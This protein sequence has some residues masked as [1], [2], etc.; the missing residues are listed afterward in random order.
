M[1]FLKLIYFDEPF[2]TD[3]MQ[4]IDGGEMKKTTELVDSIDTKATGDAGLEAGAGTSVKGIPR[5]LSFLS[6][7]DISMAA[8]TEGKITK[9]KSKITKNILE[10]T[11]MADFLALVKADNR[12][13]KNKR[14]A[15]IEIFEDVSVRPVVNSF[16]YLML[17][18]PFLEM[19]E[20]K[21]PISSSD[22]TSF[23]L[24]V[25]KIESAI[26]KGR[27]Y[28]E[29]IAEVQGIRKILRFNLSSFRNEYTMSDLPKMTLTY[30]VIKVGKI[31][32]TDLQVQKEFEFGA[33][34][35]ILRADYSNSM[36]KE[37]EKFL[38]VY[39]VVLAGVVGN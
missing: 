36:G 27:G 12:R 35:K 7:V 39:D 24:D 13:S 8:E 4:I 25:R 17:V 29:F 11:M 2:V 20:G 37:E 10:N 38:D 6:G 32:E 21:I 30:Y 19:V 18:A 14:C 15:G 3:F 5:I 16:T 28:Y 9:K 23:N 1:N 33:T 26:E 34:Q 22:G 31:K